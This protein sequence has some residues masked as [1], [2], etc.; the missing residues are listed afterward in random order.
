MIVW[1]KQFPWYEKPLGYYLLLKSRR[2]YFQHYGIVRRKKIIPWIGR[3]PGYQQKL[4]ALR[5]KHAGQRCF[6]IGNGPSLKKMDVS[7]L[8][9][10]ITIGCN[11][12]YKRFPEWGFTTNYWIME[13][14]NQFEIRRKDVFKIKGPIK[15]AA[16]YNA[17]N[18]RPDK[19][20]VFFN[21][22]PIFSL[23]KKM[24]QDGT[25]PQFSKDFSSIAYL[26]GTVSFLMIQLAYFLGCD[27]IYL[28]GFDHN[29]GL[30]PKFF[31]VGKD[32]HR[33]LTITEENY[34]LVQKCHFDKKYYKIGDTI[35]IPNVKMQ[36]S[37]YALAKRVIEEEGRKILS[38]GVDS[39]L[40]IFDKVDFNS[41]FKSNN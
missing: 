12:I 10:E 23:Y 37:S 8:K 33:S 27:P 31:P 30:L 9:N 16:L 36:E 15:L 34:E 2:K 14:I 18:F 25:L 1:T 28:I 5:N 7:L 22:A 40:N 41:L 38:A 20:T 26:G 17:Y 24:W 32:L 3:K 13:D 11:A 4:D 35:G 6:I 39:K 21:A 19:N 29:Y